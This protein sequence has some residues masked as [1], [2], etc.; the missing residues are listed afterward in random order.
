MTAFGFSVESL[1]RP[2]SPVRLHD[3][4]RDGYSADTEIRRR[5]PLPT[6]TPTV[7]LPCLRFPVRPR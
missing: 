4:E 7:M 6:T 1:R 5:T 2:D 3:A